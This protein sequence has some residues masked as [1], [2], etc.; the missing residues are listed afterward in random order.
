M[1]LLEPHRKKLLAC[2]LTPET[3]GRAGLHSGSEAEVKDV[4]GYGGAG[5]GLVIPYTDVYARVRIDNPGP[6]GKRYRSP[7][8]RG[9]RLY[10]P[11]NLNPG[12]LADTS[13]PLHVTEG[14]FKALKACQDGLVC[15]ALPGVWSWKT[16]LHGQSLPIADLDRVTWKGRAVVIVFDSDLAE[17]PA[18][19][20][21]EHQLCQELR[22]RSAIVYVV[23]LP[24][25]PG[26]QKLGLDD[27]LVAFGVESFRRLEMISLAEGDS[28]PT[29]YRIQDL[30]DA[31]WLRVQQPHHRI[32]TGYPELDAVMRGIAPGEAMTVLGRAGVG[33]TAFA[34]NLIDRMTADTK[35]PTLMFSLEQPGVEL[36]ERMASM[37]T[38]LVG[39]EIEERARQED[40]Q[41]AAR[42]LDVCSRWHHVV[43]VDQPCTVDQL[44]ALIIA[45]RKADFW[46]EPLRLVVVDYLGLV[47]QPRRQLSPY[48]HVSFVA[49]ELKNL[50]K[51][52]RVGVVTLCQVNRE[53]ESGGEPITLT[54][55]RE[56]GV[57]EEAAD[58]VLGIWRPEL[59]DGL[60]KEQR[61]EMRGQ[62]K[63]RVLKS[64]NGPRNKTVTLHFEDSVLQISSI[65]MTVET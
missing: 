3:W 18:V 48:E 31:Y 1:T 64:R 44:D 12:A 43:T 9:N 15:V 4:L 38:G 52:H 63:V 11:A 6:D 41:L 22:G 35:L 19:A 17:K 25:G 61:Q 51:R 24:D 23:R 49:R 37:T 21:A 30:F 60:S 57:I 45:A 27:Y 29:F 56:T 2:G 33:K 62:F 20:W 26:G 59:K 40:P 13:R 16:K 36:F 28:T 7:R 32:T 54:M 55:A 5:T 65:G 14:E 42:L 39:R 50:A 46:A 53:G 58:Y 47:G 10:V 34:L 8:G